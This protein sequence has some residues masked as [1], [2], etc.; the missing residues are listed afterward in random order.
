MIYRFGNMKY[1]RIIGWISISFAP[2]VFYGAILM[3]QFMMQTQEPSVI[4]YKFAFL[5][6]FTILPFALFVVLGV[7][8][9]RN[10]HHHARYMVC[11]IFGPLSAGVVRIFHSYLTPDSWDHAITGTYVL[12]ELVIA[13]LILDDYRLGKIRAPYIVCLV[14]FIVQHVAIYY[15]GE[16]EW[17]RELTSRLAEL[18]L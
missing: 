4:I 7:I 10:I 11:T 15:V 8:N 3:I 14:I 17:W 5:D 1:H 9:R 12:F 18:P 16:W 2:V 6:V 13:L